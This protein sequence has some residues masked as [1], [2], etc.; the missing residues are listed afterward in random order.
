MNLVF[1]DKDHK[2]LRVEMDSALAMTPLVGE[3]QC[4]TKFGF[5]FTMSTFNQTYTFALGEKQEQA[6]GF[7]KTGNGTYKYKFS[8]REFN[9]KD[10]V[11]GFGIVPASSEKPHSLWK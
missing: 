11:S 1:Y 5:K 6:I 8:P 9:T 7:E 2:I 3:I 4:E 10:F